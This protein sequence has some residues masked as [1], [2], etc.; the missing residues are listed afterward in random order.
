MDETWET[1]EQEELLGDSLFFAGEVG[2]A[3][4]YQLAQRAL[5]PPGVMFDSDE[6]SDRRMEAYQRIVTKL[7]GIGGDGRARSTHDG[8]PHPRFVMPPAPPVPEVVEP[9][10]PLPETEPTPPPLPETEPA[11][12]S[13][14]WA[15]TELSR[16]LATNDWWANHGLGDKWFEAAKLLAEKYP[17]ESALACEWSLHYFGKYAESWAAHLPASRWDSDGGLEMEGVSRLKKSL[18]TSPSPTPPALWI[19]SL[20][21]GD[22]RQSLATF[23]PASARDFPPL[24][25]ILKQASKSGGQSF[26]LH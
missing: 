20:V 7:Y 3:L 2:A 8:Q 12:V 15:P 5:M 21:A 24:V 18:P 4:H 22:W 6:E 23:D 16:V 26:P 10:L 9:P 1:A 11:T 13:R 17:S 25:G 19:L 14:I